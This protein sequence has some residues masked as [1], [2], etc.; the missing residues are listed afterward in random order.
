MI[1]IADSGS[2]KTDWRL[3]DG[4]REI[5]R[6]QTKGFNPYYQQLG[7]MTAEVEGSLSPYVES[8]LV[9]TIFFY[10]AGCSTAERQKKI[11]DALKP[12]FRKAAIFVYSDLLGAAR[13]LSGNKPGIVCILGT[14]SGSCRYDGEKIAENIPS[15]GFILGDEGSGAWLG[16]K[17][18]TDFLRGHM[19][20]NCMELIRKELLIDKE[21]ILEQV[22]HKPMP[23][24]YLA[25]F[26]KFISEHIDQTYFYKL[27]FDSFTAFAENYIIRYD[28]YAETKCHFVGSVAYY[29]Q[30]ILENVAKY[31]GF[32]IGN[33]IKSPIDGLT[34]YHSNPK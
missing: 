26:A 25:S 2:T 12:S 13:A 9:D 28:H 8:E 14:G 27:I 16:K 11:S 21:I 31:N 10:G 6:I 33:I 19:P 20:E 23:S 30:E 24:R 29:N 18:V 17:M 15:L 7:E 4:S 3:M 32:S 34:S 22:N 1:L 5:T